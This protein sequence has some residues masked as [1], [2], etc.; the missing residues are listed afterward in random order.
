[1]DVAHRCADH[2]LNDAAVVRSSRRPI[3][4]P[5]AVLL[6]PAPQCLALELRS[7]IQEQRFRL[8]AHRPIRLHAEPF[9]PR[10]F[11]TGCVGKAQP[12]GH[13]RRRLQSDDHSHERP[14]VH[15]DR[16]SQIRAA[17]RSTLALIHDDHV[18]DRV[19]DLYLLQDRTDHRHVTAG[20]LQRPHSVSAFPA[21]ADLNRVKHRD[22]PGH[23]VPGRGLQS[24]RR[25]SAGD[26]AVDRR[27][28]PLLTRKK[29][30]ADQ[31]AN[32]FLDRLR[33]TVPT[34]ATS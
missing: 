11:I 32:D 30:T 8:P 27:H 2:A 14:A 6:A 9:E 5:N 4:Q 25:A 12:H 13:S 7:V 26:L 34:L 22:A 33:Q 31:V 19:V 3:G 29:P 1:M 20:G 24:S 28:A 18:N 10:P 17:N 23:R 16:N 15:I 21:P